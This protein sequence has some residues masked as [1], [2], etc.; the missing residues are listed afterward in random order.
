[1]DFDSFSG[2]RDGRINKVFFGTAVKE[3]RFTFFRQSGWMLFA[4]LGGG[5]FMFLVQF[6]AQRYLPENPQTH[7]TQLGVFLTLRNALAQMAIPALG[8]QT[9]FAHQAVAAVT[10]EKK[11]EL[12]ATVRGVAKVLLAIWLCLLLL[13][14]LF[15]QQLLVSYKV[16]NPAALWLTLSAALVAMLSPIFAGLL[17]GRQDF[18]WFG[19]AAILGGFTCFAATL[20]LVVGL[21]FEAA[22]IMAALFASTSMGLLIYAW[23]TQSFWR[24]RPSSFKWMDWLR[25]VVPLTLGLATFTYVFT[26]D[27]LVVQQYFTNT[28]GYGAAR[29]V[30]AAL[31]FLTTPLGAVLFPKVVR[32]HALSEKTTVLGQALGATGLIGVC[33][34]LACTAFPELPLR[35]LSKERF[36]GSAALVPW[37]AW[38]MLPLAVANVLTNNL[39]ARERYAAVPWLVAVAAGYGLTLRYTH[40]SPL[41]VIQTLGVFGVLLVLVCVV[42]TVRQPRAS[43]TRR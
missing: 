31:V 16:S 28:D 21:H 8:L 13:A 42:F 1:M 15:Q 26:Q 27:M 39:L 10:E 30:G 24:E 37:F 32:S 4:T 29:T 35:V 33:A 14:F 36:I 18:F 12:A 20:V 9:V 34:A 19:W 3:S 2:S 23:R 11:R 17:Q 6:A 41:A 22:G 5:A 38:C 43:V 25:R 40:T 7:E